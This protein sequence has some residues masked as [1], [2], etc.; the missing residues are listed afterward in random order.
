MSLSNF[1]R[2]VLAAA[3]VY[4]CAASGSKQQ[5]TSGGFA[6]QKQVVFYT[7]KPRFDWPSQKGS[8]YRVVLWRVPNAGQ[9]QQTVALYDQQ[10]YTERFWIPP[11]DLDF[12]TKYALYVYNDRQQVVSSWG[13]AIGYQPPQVQGSLATA[14]AKVKNL[15]PVI[16]VA[17]FEYENVW[18]SYEIS[19]SANFDKLIDKGFIAQSGNVRHFPGNDNE[20]NTAD[21]V[22]YV[23]YSVARVLKPNKTYYWR[24]RGYYYSSKDLADGKRPDP[25][26]ALGFGEATGTFSIP[27]QSGSDSLANITQITRDNQDTIEPTINRRNGLAYVSCKSLCSKIDN[28][29]D[30]GSDIRVAA[31]QMRN[32]TPV[33]DTGREEFTKSV[34]GSWDRHPQW[35]VDNDGIFFD[36]DRSNGVFNIWYKRRDSRG[37]TQLTFHQVNAWGPT[38]SKD[39]NK[40]AYRVSNPENRAQSSIW[41]V[42][43]DGRAATELGEGDEPAFSPD[44]KRIAF[45]AAGKEGLRQIWVMDTNGGNRVQ[46]T[47]EFDNY[48]PVW[49]PSGRKLI[50]VS[51]RAENP[52]IWVADLDSA[53]MVQLTNYFGDDAD[54]EFTPDGRYL[55]FASTRGGGDVH[56]LWMGELAND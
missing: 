40:V 16:R 38:V 5:T 42:D 4:V 22:R 37:Y 12:E 15:S 21:D 28:V 32:G 44:G 30:I 34:R 35:D 20:M 2:I 31:V 19:E 27:P 6:T 54:P 26:Q 56:H 55:M 49:H 52:D 9:P 23:Q 8:T 51:T 29:A 3:A 24:V 36:S 48:T 43:R 7:T 33:Y 41:I 11:D 18:I 45:S 46:I 14:N 47:N 39:G 10:N 13:F 17:P 1:V 25:A 50:F 53:K